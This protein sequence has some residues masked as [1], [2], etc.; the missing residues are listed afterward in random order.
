MKLYEIVFKEAN[1]G[2]FRGK[3]QKKRFLLTVE[4]IIVVVNNLYELFFEEFLSFIFLCI[5][6]KIFV[7]SSVH[8]KLKQKSIWLENFVPLVFATFYDAL[9]CRLGSSN[10][11][12]VNNRQIETFVS[13]NN[14]FNNNLKTK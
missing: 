9:K 7:I 11:S 14:S 8:E 4:K 10:N 12:S 6:K 1:S 2:I 3:V 13:N 5:L